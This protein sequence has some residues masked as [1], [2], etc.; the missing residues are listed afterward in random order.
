MYTGFAFGWLMVFVS[1]V[2][3]NHLD[4]FGVRQAWLA[5]RGRPYTPLA[6]VTPGPYKYIRH[7]LYVGWLFTFWCTPTM[8]ATHAFFALITTA[9]IFVAIQLE[10]HDLAAAHPDYQKYR[11]Q[12]PMLIPSPSRQW[13]RTEPA[14]PSPASEP[15]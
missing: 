11:D 9:Y 8:T 14:T 15:A 4:L 10:E 1:T 7:P 3:I 6:F 12:V 5:F 13:N 2:L